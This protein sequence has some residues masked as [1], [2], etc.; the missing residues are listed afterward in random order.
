MSPVLLVDD[1]A[2]EAFL[3][4]RAFREAAVKN[5]VLVAPDGEAAIALIGERRPCL[6]LMD[7]KLP[8][9]SGLE[10]LEWVRNRSDTPTLPVI[11]LSASTYQS[12]VRAAY[13][14]GA[15]GYLVKPATYE[16]CVAMARAVKDYWLTFNR[17]P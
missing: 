9:R 4:V 16:A 13:L 11:L 17:A 8:G 7:Q 15:N 12:D 2:D 1:D 6:V 10:V 3:V 14:V 5:E